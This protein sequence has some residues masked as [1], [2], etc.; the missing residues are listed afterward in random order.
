MNS[1]VSA[2]V[3]KVVVRTTCKQQE[4]FASK[5]PSSKLVLT[6]TNKKLTS[7]KM[8]LSTKFHRET[9]FGLA[10]IISFFL[11]LVFDGFRNEF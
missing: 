9:I 10:Y 6:P 4:N 1:Y 7:F 11:R 2:I 3:F 5:D 8:K